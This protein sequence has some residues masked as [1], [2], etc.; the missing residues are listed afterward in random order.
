[1]QDKLQGLE[2]ERDSEQRLIWAAQKRKNRM[3]ED[4]KKIQ[5]EIN[6]FLDEVKGRVSKKDFTNILKIITHNKKEID[7][8]N[9][10]SD[11]SD[12]SDR[13]RGFEQVSGFR[14]KLIIPKLVLPFRFRAYG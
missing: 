7:N 8:P 9:R 5:E 4:I 14:T 12:V 2:N 6:H 1:L 10:S 13:F 3:M 11:Q